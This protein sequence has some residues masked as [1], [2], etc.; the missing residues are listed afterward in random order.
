MKVS[1]G[2]KKAMKR[3]IREAKE[4]VKQLQKQ[5]N[6]L[7]R[8]NNSKHQHYES[9]EKQYDTTLDMLHNINNDIESIQEQVLY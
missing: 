5:Q 2:Q 9:L 1:K 7:Q 6:D 3:R 4:C 8:I